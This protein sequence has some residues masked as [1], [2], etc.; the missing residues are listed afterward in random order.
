MHPFLPSLFHFILLLH[1]V[2]FLPPQCYLVH[3]THRISL[4]KSSTM[5]ASDYT[6]VSLH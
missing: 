5:K 6:L 1:I 4:M 2:P 3:C